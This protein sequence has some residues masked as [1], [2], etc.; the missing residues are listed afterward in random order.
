MAVGK[1]PI[2]H[3]AKHYNILCG[4]R[5]CNT[6]HTATQ[7]HNQNTDTHGRW[8][9][10]QCCNGSWWGVHELSEGDAYGTP[11]GAGMYIN[12]CKYMCRY[13]YTYVLC[14]YIYIMNM[15]ICR[16]CI[17][18]VRMRCLRNNHWRRHIFIYVHVCRCVD[19]FIQTWRYIYK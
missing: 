11:T 3:A 8:Q 4:C 12:I 17:W 15:Y 2:V 13:I 19:I 10:T 5:D 6:W 1:T 7:I 18:T 16:R 14:V 9:T